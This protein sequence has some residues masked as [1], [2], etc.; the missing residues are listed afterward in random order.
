MRCLKLILINFLCMIFVHYLSGQEFTDIQINFISIVT[1][2]RSEFSLQ[3]MQYDTSLTKSLQ[4]LNKTDKFKNSTISQNEIRIIL[5]KNFCYD[6]NFTVLR[7]DLSEENG[8]SRKNIMN[9]QELFEVLKNNDY[10]NYCIL[11]END[12]AKILFLVTMR[13]IYFNRIPKKRFYGRS[14]RIGANGENIVERYLYPI[15]TKEEEF[16][17]DVFDYVFSADNNMDNL[18]FSHKK[19][20]ETFAKNANGEIIYPYVYNIILGPKVKSC[21]IYNKDRKILTLIPLYMITGGT[22]WKV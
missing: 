20:K 16:Y 6:Y 19:H 7:I 13:Y 14:P 1:G 8:L 9:N 2:I 5:Q 12:T 3:E 22:E 18:T 17:I 11:T 4:E 10:N 15:T 21:V